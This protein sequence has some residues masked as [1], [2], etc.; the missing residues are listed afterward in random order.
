MDL[1]TIKQRFE[2]IGNSAGLNRAIEVAV[3]V[4]PTDLSVLITGESGVGKE[5]F[6]QIIHQ[7]SSR[8]HGK[9]IAVNCGAIPE[10]TI[11]SELF[12]HEKG[13][14]T[15]AL[16]D[17]KGYFQEADGGTIFLDEIG[18]LPLSTQ[19]RLLRVLESGEFIRVGSSKVIKTN[20]RVIAATN[21]NI[22]KAIEE[23]HFREDLYYRLNTVPI[24]VLPLRERTDDI[25]L[26]F[27]KFARD[28]AE[29]YRMPPVRLTEDAQTVLNGY[30]WPGN[31]R[32][33]KNVT[34]QISII[35]QE[36]EIPGD[37]LRHYLPNEGGA[38]LPAIFARTESNQSFANEREILYKV[39]FDMK[40]DMN[41]LKKLVL[42]LM[43]N[44]EAPISGDQAKI[45]RN[46]YHDEGTHLPKEPAHSPIHISHVD[47]ENIQDTEEFV[48]ESLSLADKEIELIKKALDKHRGKRKYAAQ[49]LGISERTLYRKI[50]EYDI[51]G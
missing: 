21:V 16:A 19:V 39:L 23:G 28:F 34:E 17:R 32:Q 51:K 11:D 7:F 27:R 35:E 31:I 12:G 42:D 6:P 36:R 18:E 26:L 46:L 47:K 9:Y 3:Q 25:N 38:N 49:E 22:P 5:M 43:E 41:D 29:K 50:K 8:K 44:R 20:V 40:N 30:R 24:N 10:G 1:Q 13:A 15:G 2:I 48:E 33:L 45:I 14:F 37:V 4:A